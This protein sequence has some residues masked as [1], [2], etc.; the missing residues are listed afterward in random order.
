MANLL[1]SR[2]SP[3]GPASRLWFYLTIAFIVG[4]AA[5]AFLNGS[6]G[7]RC[8]LVDFHPAACS[9]HCYTPSQLTRSVLLC[10][11]T[12]THPAA[13]SLP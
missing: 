1:K 5:D 3:K 2:K 9:C 13:V 10:R 6:G 7:C 11:T 12:K 4:F 8:G